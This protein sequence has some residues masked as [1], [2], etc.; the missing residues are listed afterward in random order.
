MSRLRLLLR[1][2]FRR[3]AA[4]RDLDAELE[5]YAAVLRS[6]QASPPPIEQI[7]EEVR[8]ARLGAGLESWARDARLA[9]RRLRH[10][11]GLTLACALTFALGIG[12]NTVVFSIAN[13]L[14]F[15]QL[16][17]DAP[18]QLAYIPIHLQGQ[19]AQAEPEIFRTLR[20]QGGS[21]FQS[22]ARVTF[23]QAGIRAAGEARIA[24]VS[25]VSGNFF[26]L[27]GIK[28]ALG[29]FFTDRRAPVIV[30]GY[31]YWLSRFGGNRAVIGQEASVDG[32]G[33]T[34][35]GV[36]PRGF[37]GFSELL[38]AQAYVPIGLET[39]ASDLPYTPI[40]RL[41]QGV[42]RAQAA[43]LLNVV[44]QRVEREHPEADRGLQI[45]IL[46]L[47]NDALFG[48]GDGPDPVPVMAALFLGLA[49]AVLLLAAANVVGILLARA[50]TQRRELAV[51]AAL[52][53]SRSRLARQV[54]L[55]TLW[56]ALLGTAVG[57]G[58]G[59]VASRSISGAPPSFGFPLVLDFAFDLRVFGYSAL[60][61]LVVALTA[62]LAPAL[63]ASRA[64]PADA[65]RGQ[66]TGAS[67]RQRL[68][69]ILVAGQVAG[70]LALLIAGGLF[71][72]SL[73]HQSQIQLGFAPDH[74]WTFTL[75]ASGAG[76][77]P[78]R[79]QQV[80]SALLPRVRALPGVEAA[81]MT[82]AV[83]LGVDHFGAEAQAPGQPGAAPVRASVSH[84]VIT[85]GYFS[86]LRIPLL[87]GRGFSDND[88]ANS[89]PVAIVSVSLAHQ[90]WPGRNPLGRSF[91]LDSAPGK[92]LRVVGVV[93]DVCE[94]MGNPRAPHAYCPLSQ[95]YDTS[96][97]LVVRAARNPVRAV[98]QAVAALDPNLPIG[99]VQTMETS[100]NGIN[101]LFLF[102]LGAGLAAG[103][104]LLA[105]LLAL[106]GVYGVV[107]YAA[108][109]RTHE[110]GV[111]VALGAGSRQVAA[112]VLR[113]A[114]PTIASGLAL[115][116]LLAAGLG[117][118]V[119]AFL[120]G[121]S[122][123]DPLTFIAAASLLAAAALAAS[124]IPALR[125]AGADPLPA[126]RCE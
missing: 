102:R 74:V 77:G 110:F 111:R 13:D 38:D 106:V 75:D 66:Q 88:K 101:G 86:S 63:R 27:M 119:G 29:S 104:G 19:P 90:L 60:L 9:A 95:S 54:F 100:I 125:A 31:D 94:S 41:R 21:V 103:L 34:I 25:Y 117:K 50:S 15:R 93:G 122:G 45:L 22:L 17:V 8:S 65:L 114:L 16:P 2:L 58:F 80:F 124:L 44:A 107:A 26:S 51:R 67:P 70:S 52:G 61:A 118:L 108:A 20:E 53:A 49:G 116:L 123:L 73:A 72:R 42:T 6:R 57:L 126:L 99:G 89:P 97:V 11:P 7:R 78:A 18:G 91:A 4:N 120:V 5:A 68:R 23:Q 40:A 112:A 30:L 56:L 12:A 76:Y 59:I 98:E 32:R 55:E 14:L 3:R 96:Q 39:A 33:V 92:L 24:Y 37:Y 83:P 62:G 28:P 1:N 113:Q 84:S 105:L 35:A 87:S 10:A 109:Q 121:I 46:P 82:D 81:G 69:A 85:H 79:G 36:A 43:P 115:G 47:T 64:Q 48:K 71:A